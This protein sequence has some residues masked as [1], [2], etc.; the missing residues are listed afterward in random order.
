M[1]DEPHDH[2]VGASTAPT[3]REHRTD[4]EK[5]APHPLIAALEHAD[6][7]A[8]E[9][10][11]YVGPS[12]AD[13]VRLYQALSVSSYIEI[14]KAAIVYSDARD[15]GAVRV[16]VRA[17]SEISVVRRERMSAGTYR[18]GPG[19]RV[20]PPVVS[21][22]SFWTC[23]ARCETAFASRASAIIVDETNA[24]NDPDERRQAAALD[25]LVQR[26]HLAKTALYAC[27]ERCLA[28]HGAP[29]S[30]IWAPFSLGGHYAAIV[31]RHLERPE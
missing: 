28:T 29:L 2:D 19:E 14:A 21:I 1:S 27:L 16:F 23:A 7:D 24:L 22:E 12:P 4:N 25:S 31:A 17:S 20:F 10:I 13:K 9:F 11:G 15:A 3:A 8:I 5:L 6:E 30:S 18:R 26:K